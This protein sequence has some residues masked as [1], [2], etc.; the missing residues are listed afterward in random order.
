MMPAALTVLICTR[1]GASVLPRTLEAY[2]RVE[3]PSHA[4][5]MVI[6]DNGS[7]DSTPAILASFKNRLPI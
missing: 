4:W 1:N 3:N 7:V 2:C 5:K 6:V